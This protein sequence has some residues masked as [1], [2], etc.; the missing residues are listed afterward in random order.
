MYNNESV[1]D[2]LSR[3]SI[4]TNKG[5]FQN[6]DTGTSAFRR[7]SYH[8]LQ[9]KKCSPNGMRHYGDTVTVIC[10]AK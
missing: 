7:L 3:S 2:Y 6:Q 5:V 8:H 1:V 9:N 4:N 10:D